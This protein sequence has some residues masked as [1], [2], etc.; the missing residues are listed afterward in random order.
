[1]YL[2]ILICFLLRSIPHPPNFAPIMAMCL[3]L[4]RHNHNYITILL[5]LLTSDVCQEL[6]FRLGVSPYPGLHSGMLWMYLIYIASVRLANFVK[7]LRPIVASLSFFILSNALV[8]IG[9]SMYDSNLQGLVR[10][11][12]MAIPFFKYSIL[13]D[14]LYYYGYIV[15]ALILNA[16]ANINHEAKIDYIRNY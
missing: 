3:I 14:C 11:Y 7:T 4:S 1:M 5:A 16:C 9:S 8:W 6:S 2:S 12:Y 13:S 15:G 10:C